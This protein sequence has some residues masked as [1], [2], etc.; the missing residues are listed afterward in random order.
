[1][2][3]GVSALA[4]PAHPH[5]S[6]KSIQPNKITW[7]TSRRVQQLVYCILPLY[8]DGVSRKM[9]QCRLLVCARMP[10]TQ[11]GPKMTPFPLSSVRGRNTKSFGAPTPACPLI[12][13]ACPPT[14]CPGSCAD[15]TKS[16]SCAQRSHAIPTRAERPETH[17]TP[18]LRTPLAIRKRP[19]QLTCVAR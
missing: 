17:D 2:L 8:H 16:R 14:H 18:H 1:V 6:D 4:D 19:R 10:Q 5:P 12:P 11:T 7:L 9:C 15:P 13:D 3:V